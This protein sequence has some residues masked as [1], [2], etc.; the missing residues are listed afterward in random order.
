M[1]SDEEL[2]EFLGEYVTDN[3][4]EKIAAALEQRTRYL[5]IVLEDIYQPHNASA[6]LRTCDCLGVQDVHIVESHN[7][8]QPN[9]GVAM[10][11]S[12]WL[13]LNRYRSVSAAV[14]TLKKRGHRIVATVPGREGFDPATLP[15]DRPVGLL[16]GTEEEGLTEAAIELA[17]EFLALPMYGF[18]QSFNISVTVAVVLSRLVE[19]LRESER[20]WRLEAAEKTSLTLGWYRKIVTRH[21]I[22]EQEFWNCENSSNCHE[23]TV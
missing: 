21:E 11:S 23:S 22:L 5:T 4:R 14:E 15:L 7:V 9:Q 2:I 3:K 18:T 8:Y 16:F 20:Q 13:T 6:C 19:R 12:K 10:G 17:D 1:T